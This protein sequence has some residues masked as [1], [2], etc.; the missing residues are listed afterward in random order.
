MNEFNTIHETVIRDVVDT[1]KDGV[2]ATE[3]ISGK[4]GY[5]GSIASAGSLSKATSGLTLTF[6]VLVDNSIP[7]ETANMISKAVETKAVSM[8]QHL[9]FPIQKMLLSLLE[10][11]ILILVVENYL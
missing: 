1:I 10:T 6:P 3:K 4:G 9:M 5:T 7:V 8:L 11:S 2:E